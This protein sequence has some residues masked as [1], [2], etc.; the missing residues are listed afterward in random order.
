MEI[1]ILLILVVAAVYLLIGF[2]FGIA[3][4]WFGLNRIDPAASNAGVGFKFLIIPGCAVFW[5]YL[6]VRWMRRQTP[7]EERS[8][9]RSAAK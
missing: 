2:L 6:L 4:V 1:L 9:H 7:P 3:F 5:P 8:V